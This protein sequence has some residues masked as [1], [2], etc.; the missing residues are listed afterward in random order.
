MKRYLLKIL[1]ISL[2]FMRLNKSD[3]PVKEH[4]GNLNEGGI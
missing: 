1:Y 4:L 2:I 3:F